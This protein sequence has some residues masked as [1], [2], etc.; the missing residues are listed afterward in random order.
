MSARGARPL[1]STRPR[2]AR[3]LLRWVVPTIFGVVTGVATVGLTVAAGM[4]IARAALRPELF[5]SLTLLAVAVRGFGVARA[6]GRYAER[7]SGHLAALM[8]AAQL[9]LVVFDR[10]TALGDAA[11]R[12]GDL[13]GRIHTDID[14]AV[15]YVVRVVVPAVT[16]ATVC[17]AFAGWLAWLNPVLLLPMLIPTGLYAA[18]VLVS[19]LRIRRDVDDEIRATTRHATTLLDALA[20]TQDGAAALLRPRL[21]G[22]AE[23]VHHARR[24]Q[25]RW[26]SHLIL[27]R[28]LLLVLCLAGL[29]VVGAS[30]L[31]AE[32]LSGPQLV[33]AVLGALAFFEVLGVFSAVP[34]A[35]QQWRTSAHHSAELATAQPSILPAAQPLPLPPGPTRF[36]LQSVGVV[37]G[38]RTVLRDVTVTFDPGD[39]VVITGPSGHGKTTLLKVLARQ[40]EIS[41]GRILCSGMDVHQADPAQVRARIA[42]HAQD[43]PVLDAT[44]EENLRLGAGAAP[45]EALET[46]L[47]DLG[48]DYPLTHQL[49]ERGERISGGE[50]ARVSLARALLAPADVLMLDE[51][52]AHLDSASE[53][54]VL[55]AIDRHARGRTV[56]IVTHRPGP[57]ALAHRILTL[58]DGVLR[59]TVGAATAPGDQPPGIH[60]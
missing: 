15:M 23:R 34:T 35:V 11:G 1:L 39:R 19:G 22:D 6:G 33:G 4:L 16:V 46:M 12:L 58:S 60:G 59:E 32:S 18:L 57:L 37:R 44:L 17:A 31:T 55:A 24:G 26:D 9:R 53:S 14:A 5:A 41:S 7:F 36:E 52:T 21:H 45:A 28:E 43:A 49:G 20:T 30:L 13:V 25:A 47:T 56:L 48:L 50:R 40:L 8:L 2:S 27:A 42:V 10:I 3:D 51:P 54:L 29:I 38:G